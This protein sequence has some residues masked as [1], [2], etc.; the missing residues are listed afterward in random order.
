[1]T[2][3]DMLTMVSRPDAAVFCA[4]LGLFL[5]SFY[6][7]CV[8]RFFT[9]ES[10]VFPPSH[11]THCGERLRPWELIP[12]VSW[13]CL[14]GKCSHCG[15]KL[16][17]R[18]PL[19]ELT[20]GLLAGLIGW[21]FGLT[22]AGFVALIFTGLW[23]VMSLIDLKAKILPDRMNLPG[24]VLALPAGIFVFGLDPTDAVIGGLAGAAVFWLV[25]LY[26]QKRTG[27]EGLG[28]GD[29]KL[30]LMLGF[31]TGA[32][33]LPLTVIFAGVA[34]LFGFAALKLIGRTEGAVTETQ[35]PFGP[36]LCLAAWVNLL[37]G[38]ALWMAWIR[39]MTQ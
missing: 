25:R 13:L 22:A 39:F 7:V 34:A 3:I 24:A 14:R 10:I 19:T 28:L 15:V 32:H 8:D 21:R 18:Y 30:M 31:L 17:I 29:V 35:L 4:V 33:L 16:S 26:Y 37:W 23:F 27:T 12:V 11:C 1:M 20:S 2:F 6:C 9:G 36:F 38:D 5:G